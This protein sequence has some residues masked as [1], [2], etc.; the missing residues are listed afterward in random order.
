MPTA[1]TLFSR[2]LGFLIPALASASL[3]SGCQNDR[4]DGGADTQY[5][6]ATHNTRFHGRRDYH[7]FTFDNDPSTP[8]TRCWYM[9][10]ADAGTPA[11]QAMSVAE[12]LVPRE[13]DDSEVRD[14]LQD[15]NKGNAAMAMV[16]AMTAK[17]ACG[18]M[19]AAATP[20]GPVVVA[21]CG[22]SVWGAWA[23]AKA[24][25]VNHAAAGAVGGNRQGL[26]DGNVEMD[27]KVILDLAQAAKARA[28]R[29]RG[30]GCWRSNRIVARYRDILTNTGASGSQAS[31]TAPSN[32][33]HASC[34]S[35]RAASASI[36]L[37]TGE[38]SGGVVGY[39]G[40]Q[41]KS[42]GRDAPIRLFK[43]GDSRGTL[44]VY[45]KVTGPSML[46]GKAGWAKLSDLACE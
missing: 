41:G 29:A 35:Y 16:N 1:R 32:G 27:P 22:L 31:T 38:T 34:A 15:W 6:S 7:F 33:A 23:S 3:L 24:A 44:R 12:M 45:V 19:L 17:V 18:S 2:S 20:A 11:I 13:I 25:A 8:T 9:R 36:P 42:N 28:G 26:G 46:S 21:T 4:S 10:D 14:Q 5:S 43:A 39:V 40:Q 37:Y 30:N